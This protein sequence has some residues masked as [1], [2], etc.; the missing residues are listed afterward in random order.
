MS[1]AFRMELRPQRIHVCVIEPDSSSRIRS[2]FSPVG[3]S[4]AIQKLT[5]STSVDFN[6]LLARYQTKWDHIIMT[7]TSSET[8][9]RWW[10][11]I[12]CD[13]EGVINDYWRTISIDV[14]L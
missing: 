3:E 9:S 2:L 12:P 10:P 13:N 5:L 1:A 7:V 6:F 8:P 14:L 4:S 11:N